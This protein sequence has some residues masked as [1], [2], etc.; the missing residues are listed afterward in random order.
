[1]K[2]NRVLFDQCNGRFS[3]LRG[4]ILLEAE[5]GPFRT[6]PTTIPTA[7]CDSSVSNS[8]LHMDNG[9]LQRTYINMQW[10]A[11]HT[12]ERATPAVARLASAR[13]YVVATWQLSWASTRLSVYG[14]F[15]LNSWFPLHTI[16]LLPATD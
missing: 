11:A 12:L 16:R 14:I 3:A 15:A 2:R 13:P 8:L 4:D 1:M 5:A 6:E 10:Q 7:M 9:I